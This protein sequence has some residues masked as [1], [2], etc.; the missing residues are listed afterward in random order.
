VADAVS[1]SAEQ[2]GELIATAED[3]RRRWDGL[4][5]GM[6]ADAAARRAIDLLPQ[7]LVVTAPMVADTLG[8]SAPTARSAIEALAARGILEPLELRGVRPGRPPRWWMAGELVSA[9]GRWSR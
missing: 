6:R 7:H 4:L 2:V 3:L 5:T 8:V 9:V 1:R